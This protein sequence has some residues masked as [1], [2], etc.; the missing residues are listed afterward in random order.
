MLKPV[1][2]KYAAACE[3]HNCIDVHTSCNFGHVRAG[4]EVPNCFHTQIARVIAILN[5]KPCL[6][7][8]CVTTHTAIIKRKHR[9]IVWA[10]LGT[11]ANAICNAPQSMQW[12]I[13]YKV[14]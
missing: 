1:L 4:I 11:N 12:H 9:T 8:A 10:S 7:S 13:H 14:V 5:E 2:A 3:I 6:K